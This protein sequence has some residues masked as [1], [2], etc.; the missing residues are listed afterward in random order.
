LAHVRQDQIHGAFCGQQNN[1]RGSRWLSLPI[2]VQVG[3][4]TKSGRQPVR[5]SL[6]PQYKFAADAGLPEWSI[7]LNFSLLV[8]SN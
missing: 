1:P 2:G 6:N 3:K 4:V 7:K 5:F 8:P